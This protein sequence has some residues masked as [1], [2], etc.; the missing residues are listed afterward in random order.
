MALVRLSLQMR[1]DPSSQV[2]AAGRVRPPPSGDARHTP[3]GRVHALAGKT[4]L[5]FKLVLGHWL[6]ASDRGQ[7]LSLKVE[8]DGRKDSRSG[9][10]DVSSHFSPHHFPIL[11]HV[12]LT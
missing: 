11:R 10:A 8:N 3:R 1:T 12:V 9:T 7:N 6:K 2:S 4:F 5:L